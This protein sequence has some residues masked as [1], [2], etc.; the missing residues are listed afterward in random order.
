[1]TNGQDIVGESYKV[2]VLYLVTSILAVITNS[3]N[4]TWFHRYNLANVA[5][6]DLA[7]D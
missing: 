4:L 7:A 3:A 2:G 6:G 5:V 1:M